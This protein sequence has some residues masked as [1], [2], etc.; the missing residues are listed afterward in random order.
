MYEVHW[1]FPAL[2]YGEFNLVVVKVQHKKKNNTKSLPTCSGRNLDTAK[3]KVVFKIEQKRNCQKFGIL[4]V[5]T[6]ETRSERHTASRHKIFFVTK[7][8]EFQLEPLNWYPE[9]QSK[10]RKQESPHLS[11]YINK[12]NFSS[13]FQTYPLHLQPQYHLEPQTLQMNQSQIFFDHQ[14]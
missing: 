12:I 14:L 6:K 3:I 13:P 10:P 5:D 7:M 2:F 4:K 9:E 1:F 11:L 8:S